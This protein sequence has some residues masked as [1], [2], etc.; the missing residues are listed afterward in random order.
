MPE[1]SCQLNV[2]MNRG[3][4]RDG[5]ADKLDGDHS[6]GDCIVVAAVAPVMMILTMVKP[7]MVKM[8]ATG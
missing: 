1:S 2:N 4:G 3:I 5:G 6:G 8:M 7:M